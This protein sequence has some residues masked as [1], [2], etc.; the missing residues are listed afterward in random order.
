MPATLEVPGRGPIT[1]YESAIEEEFNVISRLA[2]AP[3][4]KALADDLWR[5]RASIEALTRQH[6]GLGKHDTCNILERQQ[7]IRGGLNICVLLH[8][9]SSGQQRKVVFCCAMPHKL[10]EAQYA[11]TVDEKLSCEIGAYLWMQENCPDVRIPCLYGFGFSDGRYFTHARYRPFLSRI[12]RI[13]AS[14]YMLLEYVNPVSGQMLS[15]T[16]RL[17][18]GISKIMLSLARLPQPRIGPFQFHDDGTVS[19]TNRPLSCSMVL[20]ENDG[21]PRTMQQIDIYR[22]TD[23]FVSDMLTF[24]DHRFLSQPNAVYSEGDCRGQMA[25]KTLLRALSHRYIKREHRHGPFLLQLTDLHA[26]NIFVDDDW[27]ITCLID[28]EWLCA[29][30]PEML[31]VPYWLTGCSIDEI[32]DECYD[33]FDE[34]QQEF[35]SVFQEK[36]G[37]TR[38]EHQ[39][40]LSKVMQDIWD[41]KGIWF[42][43]CL[44]SVNAMYFLIESHLCPPGSLSTNVERAVSQ[45]WRHDS[46][47]VVQMKLADRKDYDGELR[48]VFGE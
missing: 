39:I 38:A 28:L 8:V 43:Y 24:H 23:G 32:Q 21:A 30:P 7:W 22:C 40:S 37:Q 17:F 14:A 5:Q 31:N 2:H 19:L 29:L 35:M 25:V 10:A 16:Q 15:A 12:S 48:R 13:V 1:T 36:E 46:E 41:S 34:V 47:T 45:F 42:W 3:A 27:N 33:E 18:S 6:L 9:E 4:V 11:G 26:S 20:I 44:S